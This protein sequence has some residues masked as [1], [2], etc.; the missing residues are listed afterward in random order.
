MAAEHE[1]LSWDEAMTPSPRARVLVAH[2]HPVVRHALA[3]GLRGQGF[4]VHT[5]SD[6]RELD[7][8]VARCRPAVVL[9]DADRCVDV[10]DLSIVACA[11]SVGDA[12]LLCISCDD[13][14]EV[15]LQAFAAGSDDFLA[16]PFTVDE[17]AARVR[18]ILRRLPER[19]GGITRGTVTIDL[20]MR[21]AT[22]AGVPLNLTPTELRL[23]ATLANNPLRVF[24]KLQLLDLVWGNPHS[25]V[26]LVEVH[27][28][29]IRHKLEL[30]G[31][32]VI[33]TV[34]GVGYLYDE[35]AVQDDE[36]SAP[37]A[38]RPRVLRES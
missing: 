38:D 36:P 16:M 21:T 34:R 29:S 17:L 13:R 32:R 27:V 15:L 5:H 22:R 28:H 25:S 19:G 14:L 12:G 3:R 35:A 23:L 18:A 2:D 6:I 4:S 11:Q 7:L 33:H 26:N 37:V 31:P 1:A 10:D 20:T 30:H 24:S 8:A 9:L